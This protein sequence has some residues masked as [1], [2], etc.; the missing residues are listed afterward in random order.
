MAAGAA[1]FA[2]AA[3]GVVPCQVFALTKE[4]DVLKRAAAGAA[5]MDTAEAGK[6]AAESKR[7]EQLINQVIHINMP[8]PTCLRSSS[9][10]P[11]KGSGFRVDSDLLS[12]PDVLSGLVCP[13]DI[14]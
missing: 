1:V 5:G 3:G 12:G 2:V 6:L 14:W 10:T 9:L 8:T 13:G 7:K 4:R 11:D